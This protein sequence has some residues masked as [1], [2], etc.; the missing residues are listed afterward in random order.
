MTVDVRVL[1]DPA[2]EAAV[3][4]AEAARA[5]GAVALSGGG[6]PTP[7]YQRAAQL[8]PDW[9]RVEIFFADE[10]CVPP[11][12]ERSNFRLVR[13]AL[14]DVGA[15]IHRIEGE[16]SPDEAAARYDELVR[17]RTLD[18]V[19]LGIGPDGHT[20]SLFPGAPALD[21]RERAAVAAEAGMEPLVL[22]VTLTLPVLN[23]ARS[24]VF[25]V[26][27]AAKAAAVARA[28]GSPPSAETPA[29][30]VRARR[31][32]A[33]LDTAAASDLHSDAI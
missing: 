7:A 15:T 26:T 29:G 13:E 14:G 1:A 12:D 9:G 33:L 32:V 10:R 18:L 30:L 23:A 27:G 24:A 19:L 16:L 4:L 17:G 6:T 5:G 21:E 22:R 8:E 3:L 28:F 25:L 31:T 2:E 20:A 11:D